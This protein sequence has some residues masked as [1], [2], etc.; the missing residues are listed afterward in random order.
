MIL[1]GQTPDFIDLE[2]FVFLQEDI[3]GYGYCIHCF[4]RTNHG[5]GSGV[6]IGACIMQLTDGS[7]IKTADYVW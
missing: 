4:S 5:S 7:A 2:R 6:M 3:D 1:R